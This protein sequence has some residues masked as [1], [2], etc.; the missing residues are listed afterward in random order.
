MYLNFSERKGEFAMKKKQLACGCSADG[1]ICDQV[2]EVF[3]YVPDDAV[4]VCTNCS[5]GKHKVKKQS[6]KTAVKYHVDM[7]VQN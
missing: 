3:D 4:V 6:K 1:C 5:S 7:F 2:I